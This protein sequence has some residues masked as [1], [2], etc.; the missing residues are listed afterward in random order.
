MIQQQ[1]PDCL[2]MPCGPIMDSLFSGLMRTDRQISIS[3]A[4]FVLLNRSSM[5]AMRVHGCLEV[6]LFGNV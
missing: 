4:E 6:I 5:E 3:G 1:F 2:V